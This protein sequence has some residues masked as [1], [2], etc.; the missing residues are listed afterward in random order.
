MTHYAYPLPV[1]PPADV[2]DQGGECVD[3]LRRALQQEPTP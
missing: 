3:V 2:R 1:S